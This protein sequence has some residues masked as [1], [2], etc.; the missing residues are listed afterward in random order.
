MSLSWKDGLATVFVGAAAVLY[1]QWAGGLMVSARSTPR[2]LSVGILALGIGAC[3][4]AK[5]HMAAV[6]GVEG[7]PRPPMLYVVLASALGGV[8]LVAGVVAITAGNAVALTTLTGGMVALWVLATLHHL[9]ARTVTDVI[10]AG[11]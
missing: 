4:A 3:S 2:A 5:S 10:H 11:R 6:Y 7:R 1:L 9:I 8:S